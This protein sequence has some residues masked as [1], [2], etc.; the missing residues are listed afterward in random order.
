M[1]FCDVKD[2]RIEK[3]KIQVQLVDAKSK[4]VPAITG[5]LLLLQ[6]R[7]DDF[8]KNKLKLNY[9]TSGIIVL[10]SHWHN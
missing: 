4:Q 2:T 6:Y 3:E 7:K 8:N 1:C 5:E 10:H 9:M